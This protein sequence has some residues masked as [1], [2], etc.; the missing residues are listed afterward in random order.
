MTK[1]TLYTDINIKR[2]ENFL[3]KHLENETYL[4][5]GAPTFSSVEISING[6][7]NRRCFF[8]PRVDEKKYPN[9]LNSL[10]FDV[11]LKLI[12]DLKKINF[13]GR[14]SFSGFCEP[15][16]TKNLNEYI[17][18][19]REYLPNIQIEIVSNGDPLVSKNGKIRLKEL[20]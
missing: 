18:L 15:L 17:S 19:A 12:N 1:K 4:P 10:D 13:D 11:Y 5:T 2:M 9:I 14:I 3:D 8:C 20:L 16:L 6:A 7:C